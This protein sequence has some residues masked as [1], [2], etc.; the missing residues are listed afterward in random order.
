MTPKADSLVRS[1]HRAGIPFVL[2]ATGGG[3][4]A[5][6]EL[7][8]VPGG[9]HCVLEAIVPYST[10]SLTALLK[11]RPEQFCSSYTA[12]LMAMAAYERAALYQHQAGTT[13][14]VAGVACTA[15]LVSDRP[16]RGP[17]RIHVAGQTAT[18]TA[19]ASLE[20][21]K[22][23]RDRAQEELLAAHVLLNMVA[24]VC[25]VVE[26]IPLELR[27]EERVEA[28]TLVGSPWCQKLFAGEIDA[29]LVRG[30]VD[31]DAVVRQVA[32]QDADRAGFDASKLTQGVSI[33]YETGN[34]GVVPQLV[35]PGAFH[36]LHGGHMAMAMH[37]AARLQMRAEWEISIT[38]VDKPPLDFVEMQARASQFA[39]SA[40]VW[41]TRAPTFVEKS[42]IFPAATFVVGADTITRIADPRYYHDD[43]QACREAIAMI[44]RRDCRFLVFGR[45][46]ATGYETLS[47]LRLPPELRAICDEVSEVD[48]RMDVSSTDI[49][50]HA[51]DE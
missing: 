43:E 51:A 28:L 12:R 4:E 7:L 1:I 13:G 49:R 48:F 39:G 32:K 40:P 3:S 17:H 5:V 16:K 50:R 18:L 9:S 11:A 41:L 30:Q 46:I 22:G 20:L 8:R 27:N 45:K 6:A 10:E 21:E 15:S 2:A 24:Q 23:A 33:I 31:Y 37:A 25:N 36:P 42:A 34:T 35:F 14:P 26:R 29:V 38:N 19:T 44:A 47:G